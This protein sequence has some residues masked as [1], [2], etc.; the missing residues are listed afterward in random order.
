M[1]G[2]V[3]QAI[4]L[5]AD[6]GKEEETVTRLTRVGFDNIIGHLKGGF[7]SWKN[8]GK[9][10]DTINRISAKKFA[11]EVN[12]GKS[13]VI[14]IRRISEYSAE[15]VAESYNRP[16]IEINEWIKEINPE[17]HFYLHCAGGYRSM[18]AASILEARGYRNFSEI[19]GG[20]K[21]ISETAIP[22]TDFVCQS[23]LLTTK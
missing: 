7:N 6:V 8:A 4:I 23:K 21:D 16:L 2:N 17:E 3:K 13:K 9:E 10:V 1:V 20:F 15:H 11:E 14:D 18:I 5:I 12:I 22:K 19:E